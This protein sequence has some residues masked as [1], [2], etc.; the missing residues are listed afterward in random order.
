MTE[1]APN[2]HLPLPLHYKNSYIQI[3]RATRGNPMSHIQTYTEKG[4]P[5]GR[6]INVE[7]IAYPQPDS[8][9]DGFHKV[10]LLNSAGGQ[11]VIVCDKDVVPEHV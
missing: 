7:D 5:T 8:F 11:D 10:H 1:P 2:P 9:K 6:K 3:S 4:K